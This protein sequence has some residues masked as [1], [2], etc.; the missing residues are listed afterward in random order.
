M[1]EGL[2]KEIIMNGRNGITLGIILAPTVFIIHHSD[3]AKRNIR[4]GKVKRPLHLSRDG[5]KTIYRN[6]VVRIQSRQD[7]SCQ[8]ILLKGRHLNIS[9]ICL[10]ERVTKLTNASRRIEHGTNFH[11]T[12][13]KNRGNSIN[14]S[15]R[16]I[17]SG[18]DTTLHTVNDSTLFIVIRSILMDNGIQLPHRTEILLVRNLPV[19]LIFV[20]G[21]GVQNKFQTTETTVSS[22]D[23]TLIVIRCATFLTQL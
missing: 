1:I 7:L 15:T 10:L 18:I 4:G 14:D 12:L 22:Q 9:I 11:T 3:I 21:G 16:G 6:L 13:L 17:E 2:Q 20:T 8:H 23:G 19:T 5:L